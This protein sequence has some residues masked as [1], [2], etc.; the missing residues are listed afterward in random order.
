[1]DLIVWSMDRTM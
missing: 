1:M